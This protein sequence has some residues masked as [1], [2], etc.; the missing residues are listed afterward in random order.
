VPRFPASGCSDLKVVQSST[1]EIAGT[2]VPALLQV[3]D[4]RS[5]YLAL[6][7]LVYTRATTADPEKGGVLEKNRLRPICRHWSNTLDAYSGSVAKD[8]GKPRRMKETKF[9]LLNFTKPAAPAM[10]WWPPSG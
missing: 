1:N 9:H 5:N 8:E 2:S 7:P 4:M 6:I 3:S 10:P